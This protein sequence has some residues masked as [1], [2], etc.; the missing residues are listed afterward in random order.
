MYY[1]ILNHPLKSEKD[2]FKR[3][4]ISLLEK[5]A[6]KYET[7]IPIKAKLQFICESLYGRKITIEKSLND[8]SQNIESDVL[9]IRFTFIPFR[10][11][12]Y[13]Y[14]FLFDCL[15]LFAVSDKK[16][17]M[18]ISEEIK[19]H[20]H[21]YFHKKIDNLVTQLYEGKDNVETDTLITKEMIKSWNYA[22]CYANTKNHDILFTGTMSAGKSTLINAIMG[23]AVT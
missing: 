21:S 22:R 6:K 19:S 5:Y 20:I 12:S 23:W 11:Y 13:R 14:I 17:G 16:K 3:K 1:P 2:I 4:Y 9:K 7:Q 8:Y 10:F 18:K 15:L